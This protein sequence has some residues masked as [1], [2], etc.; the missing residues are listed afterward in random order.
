[1]PAVVGLE[2]IAAVALAMV[3][4]AATLLVRELILPPLRASAAGVSG[5][6][7][8]GGPLAWLLVNAANA[9]QAGLDV[10]DWGQAQFRSQALAWWNYAVEQTA[11]Y[12]GLPQRGEFSRVA[13][14]AA[15]ALSTATY[16]WASYLPWLR[17]RVD[18]N[19]RVARA[20][21]ATMA[22]LI[23]V[24]VPELRGTQGRLQT[25]LASVGQLVRRLWNDELPNIRGI[26]AGIR[27]DLNDTARALRDVQSNT[28]PRLRADIN[29]RALQSDLL[30]L[31]DTVMRQSAQLA[32]L[33]ALAVVALA[34]EEAISNLRCH[35]DVPCTDLTQLMGQNLEGR[36][37]MLE[38][39][40]G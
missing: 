29:G 16:T 25:D 32:I 7:V 36:V 18:D 23:G 3:A 22:Y 35:M 30:H 38:V 8:V 5:I 40:T 19:E 13:A 26:E 9:I 11:Y 15:Q 10:F 20:T 4:I 24:T 28:I 2:V 6:A 31:Q 21:A 37:A 33:S 12:I 1:M 17:A 14:N 39:A 27:T 34:G